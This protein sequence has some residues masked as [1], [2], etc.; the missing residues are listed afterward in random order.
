VSP[1]LSHR[2]RYADLHDFLSRA[3]HPPYRLSQLLRAVYRRGTPAFADMSELPRGLRAQLA[4]EF[5]PS[6][7]HLRPLVRQDGEQ[8]RKVLFEGRHGARV[9]TVLA[10]YRSGFTSLC[11]STQVGCGLGCTF[12]ATG[13]VGLVRNLGADEICD[14]VLAF[15]LH[16]RIDS[17]AFMGMGEALANPHTFAALEMLSHPELHAM[18]P[19]RLTVSTVGFAPGL[20]RLVDT[21]P[22]VNITLSVHSP[23]ADERAELIPLQ[24][25]FPL[26][27]CL[28]I[29]D[30]HVAAT[31][32]KAY[33][34]YLLIDGLNDSRDHA[35]ELTRMV[36]RLKRPELFHVSVIPYNDAVGV[37]PAYRRPRAEKVR[38][39]VGEV[40]R[41]GVHVTKR[42]QFGGDLDAACGQLH[43]RYLTS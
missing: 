30:A 35:A 26:A 9:E 15:Q 40:R 10:S 32:R 34:A 2:T 33:L 24:R 38:E 16:D 25:R 36:G 7:L 41:G 23:Y 5:G 12:C 21:H 22:A 43:A 39:F 3:G 20:Q 31:R 17:V 29:L 8:V 14:Q 27:A 42:Q 6:V 18:S 4:E 37:N 13:A 11:V 28:D 1:R 19:R